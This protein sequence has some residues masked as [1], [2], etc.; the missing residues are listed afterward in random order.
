MCLPRR[1]RSSI[2]DETVS[3]DHRTSRLAAVAGKAAGPTIS[4]RA[5]MQ[6][7]NDRAARL[8]LR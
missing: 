3:D 5:T 6:Y 8:Q 4:Q 1:F 7:Q 2:A